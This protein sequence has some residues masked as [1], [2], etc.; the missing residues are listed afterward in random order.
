MPRVS[1]FAE[2]LAEAFLSGEWHLRVM[3]ARADFVLGTGG[4]WLR[5]IAIEVL[6][7][8][9]RPTGDQAALSKLINALPAFRLAR[10]E[11]R[12]PERL[13]HVLPI[14]RTMGFAR[15]PVEKLDTL[16]DVAKWLDLDDADLDWFADTRGLERMVK[17]DPLRH[18]VRRWEGQRLLEAPRARLKSLQRRVLRDI[19]ERIPVHEAAHGFVAGR[20]VRTH[21]ALHAGKKVV[22][23]FDLQRFFTN[24]GTWQAHGIFRMAGY[25]PTVSAV[26]LGLCTTRTPESVLREAPVPVPVSGEALRARHA[27]TRRL[28]DWHLPQGAPT[29]PALSN[30]TVWRMDVRLSALAASSGLTYSRYA[31]DLVFSGERASVGALSTLVGHVVRDEGHR[32]NQQKTKVMRADQ[33][34][35]VTGVVVN[36]RPAVSRA[37]F[38]ALKAQVHRVRTKGSEGVDLPALLGRIAWVSQFSPAR[39]AKLKLSLP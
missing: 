21:A 27:M 36:V 11:G 14:P 8:S 19:L 2:G 23:R 39:A 5:D 1:R 16:R 15:W 22:I 4:P 32:I 35:R 30:L 12:F 17:V 20:S 25:S 31:D 34:Q 13:T 26:L 33:R 24:V 6:Q 10:Q 9:P 29:S 7:A 37:E 28:A 18:Y 3:I 38:D